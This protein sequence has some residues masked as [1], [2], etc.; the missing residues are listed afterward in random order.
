MNLKT[1]KQ[2]NIPSHWIRMARSERFDLNNLLR[3]QSNIG[4]RQSFPSEGTF[5]ESQ[6]FRSGYRPI[7]RCSLPQRFVHAVAMPPPSITPL[8]RPRQAHHPGATDIRSG[9][10]TQ[11]LHSSLSLPA[12]HLRRLKVTSQSNSVA[13]INKLQSNQTAISLVFAF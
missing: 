6:R 2:P 7:G 9:Q 10:P 3:S 13:P 5:R 1:K 4:N 8:P 12:T 11:A